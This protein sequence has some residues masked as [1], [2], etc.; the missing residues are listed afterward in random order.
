M[1]GWRR[2]CGA[3]VWLA[4][5][6]LPRA[7]WGNDST[8]GGAPAD[9]VPLVEQHVRMLSEDV[10]LTASDTA[11]QVEARYQFQNLADKEVT[12]QVGFPEF[13]CPRER[14]SDCA[15]VAFSDLVTLVDGVAVTHRQGKLS[16]QHGWSDFLGVVWL[17]DVKFPVGRPLAVTHRYRL[18]TGGDLSGNRYTGYVTRTGRSWA[19]SIGQATFTAVLPPYV[20]AIADVD[21]PGLHSTPP[22]LV[23]D[24]GPPRVELRVE[25]THWKPEGGVF[26]SYNSSGSMTL[27]PIDAKKLAGKNGFEVIGSSRCTIGDDDVDAQSCLND[28]YAAR[29]YP[30]KNPVLQRKY[31]SGNPSFRAVDTSEGKLWVRDATPLATFSTAWFDNFDQGALTH[32]TQLLAKQRAAKGAAAAEAASGAGEL[33]ASEPLPPPS[34]LPAGSAGAVNAGGA[35]PVAVADERRNQ[36]EAATPSATRATS[37]AAATT[38]A[39]PVPAPESKPAES[40]PTDAKTSSSGCVLHRATG[41]LPAPGGLLALALGCLGMRARRRSRRRF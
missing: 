12:V 20:R 36:V 5:G 26:F 29:G 24:A 34:A 19:G 9:L 14:D 37:A 18:A 35:A 1:R 17:F 21:A 13:R 11:W 39:A 38:S 30:F 3:F 32:W 28:L 15:D 10:V 4:A 25:G 8:F 6:M 31:Y 2:A 41:S 33:S 16:K 40:K 7:A 22:R 23:L 27:E